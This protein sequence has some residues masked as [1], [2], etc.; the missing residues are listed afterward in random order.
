VR[1]KADANIAVAIAISVTAIA[2]RFIDINQPFIDDWSWRQSDV[3]SIARNYLWTGFDFAHPQI[4]WVGDQPGY[5]GTEFPILP[6]LAAICYKF[7]GVHEWIGRFQSVIF[8]A[9]SLPFFFLL[10]R[11]IFGVTAANW[12]LVFYS[13]AP[14]SLMASRCFMPDMPSLSLSI[15]GLYLFL[16]WTDHNELKCLLASALFISFSIL[17]KLPSIVIGAPLSCLAV[18]AIFD[19]RIPSKNSGDG[20][21]PSPLRNEAPRGQR[22]RLQH[23]RVLRWDLW[24]FALIAL[25]PSAIWYWHSYQIAQKFYPHHFFGAGGLRLMNAGWYGKIAEETAIGSLSFVVSALALAG[26]VF[27]IRIKRVWFFHW[28][29]LGMLAFI[30]IVGYGNRHPW[31]QLPLVP[32][33]AAFAAASCM[34]LKEL[35]K[36][37]LRLAAGLLVIWFAL[38]CYSGAKRFYRESAADLRL[39][40][41]ELRR[42]TPPNSLVI[43]ADYGDPTV[44]YY[45]ERKGWHFL[46]KE[47]IYNG[48]PAS[49]A[50]AVADL[51]A[52]RGRGATHFVVY[53]GTLWWL[54]YYK[55]FR[56][57]LAATSKLTERTRQ[58]AIYT[59]DS[60]AR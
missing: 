13:F 54:D 2:V 33:A 32:I 55:E 45:A 37:R 3:A 52:L 25:L 26:V 28:W 48:H 41:L 16:R 17:I 18:A 4:D 34:R 21:P 7:I 9:A 31:Y 11:Q 27:T 22:P 24:L 14:V 47:G 5:V 29:L 56:Q 46:E 50:D 39:L 15:I 51:E 38:L 10:I 20:Q 40:G 44:F 23:W 43:A 59:F 8:F 19:R 36:R 42:I 60:A 1:E 35:S 30:I 53:S 58:F 6:F 12:A 49:S 57:H